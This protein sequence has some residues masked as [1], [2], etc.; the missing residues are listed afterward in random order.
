MELG[1]QSSPKG[2]NERLILCMAA[3]WALQ[4]HS[5]LFVRILVLS[6]GEPFNHEGVTLFTGH[7][8]LPSKFPDTGTPLPGMGAS[9]FLPEEYPATFSSVTGEAS[10]IGGRQP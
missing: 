7:G 9:S 6:G 4:H 2:G 3:L 8:C 5:L 10:K 1:R